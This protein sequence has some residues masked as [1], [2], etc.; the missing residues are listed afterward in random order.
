MIGF[1]IV[2]DPSVNIEAIEESRGPGKS[3]ALAAGL[4][5]EIKASSGR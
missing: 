3:K 2:G 4:I 1:V 5:E